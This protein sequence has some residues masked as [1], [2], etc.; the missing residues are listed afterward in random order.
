MFEEIQNKILELDVDFNV[1]YWKDKYEIPILTKKLFHN[2]DNGEYID[3]PDEDVVT[4]KI[5]P[6]DA[7]SGSPL[8][9][10]VCGSTG[11]G[12][13]RIIKNIIKGFWKAGYKIL[14][15]EP[16]SI[17]MRNARKMG[18]G[19]KLHPKDKNEKLPVVSYVPNYIKDY[20]ERNYPQIIDKVK[21]YSPSLSK[22]DYV[23]IWQSFGIPPK[24]A[25]FIVDII[26]KG[27]S[28]I[29]YISK[30]VLREQNLHF[31]TKQA[32][33]STM[34]SLKATNFFGTKKK[35]DLK[36]EWDKNNIVVINYFSRD[37][38]FMNTDIG[39]VLDLIRDIGLQEMH[40]GLSTITKKLIIFDDAFYFAGK[41]AEMATKATKGI[42][43]ATRNISNC[44][45]NFRTWGVNTIFVVQSPDANAIHQ[46]L[47]DGC[48]TKLVTYIENP[49]ALSG[50]LPFYA[51]KLISNTNPSEP[52]LYIDE[53][54]YIFQWIYC[55]GK[56]RWKTGFSLDCTVGHS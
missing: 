55:Q 22:L 3:M 27:H 29:D 53:E 44:Q 52:M 43:L 23:E 15:F 9:M 35:L 32:I 17:E 45:N 40:N 19:V 21:F 30:R 34:E 38:A 54:H 50:K 25:S 36:K 8:N 20:L 49:F 46:N 47:I 39:L 10:L 4:V 13:T 7:Q 6:R 16:K 41:S 5:D 2:Y 33:E 14:F 28:N 11:T 18:K 12:K 31:S 51:Y 48:T 1:D 56:T 42:N 26:S 37:G 24:T